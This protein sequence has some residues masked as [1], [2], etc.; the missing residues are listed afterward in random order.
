MRIALIRHLRPDIAVG[1][2]YGRLD[3]AVA[4]DA[5]ATATLAELAEFR[6]TRLHSSPARRCHA[7]A[8]LIAPAVECAAVFD[9]ALLELDFG[10]WEGKL[11]D[12][13]PI[14][15]LDLWADNPLAFSAPGG[16]TGAS[17]VAR[18][19][20]FAQSLLAAGQDAVVVSHGG[21]L[22]IIRAVL[23]GETI[24]LFAPTQG[25]GEI[26]WIDVQAS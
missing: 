20:A 11:W 22:K 23:C 6:P 21:P 5:D 1:T 7:L 19:Q 3:I 13:V 2:C 26:V 18:T 9:D 16:E 25:M 24:D 15:A 14:D 10:A 4:P 17:L 8:A 12:E